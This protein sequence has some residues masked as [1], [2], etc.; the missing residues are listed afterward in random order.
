M[1]K[2]FFNTK[3]SVINYEMTPQNIEPATIEFLHSTIWN[4]AIAYGNQHVVDARFVCYII[5]SMYSSRMCTACLLPVSPSMYCIG[6]VCSWGVSASAPRR[7]L[8]RGGSASRGRGVCSQGV[9]LSSGGG[10]VCSQEGGLPL[11]RGCIPACNGQTP[12]HGQNSWHTLLKIL[13]CPNFVA[14][15]NYCL[16]LYLT[17]ITADHPLPF[18]S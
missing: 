9:C 17:A 4:L 14:G 13:P 11:I 18:V 8:L 2:P 15:G 3:V 12:P 5:T 10:D 6:G 7:C 1:F 16:P